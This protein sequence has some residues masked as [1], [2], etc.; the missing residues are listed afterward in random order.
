MFLRKKIGKSTTDCW[1]EIEKLEKQI[2]QA[3]AIIIGAGAGLSTSAGFHYAGERFKE[4]FGDFA[5]RYHFIDMYSGGF[6]PYET[7]EEHWTYWSRYIYINRYMDAP[8][9]VYN[10]LYSRVKEKDY[11]VLTTNVDHCFQKAGFDKHRL[12]YTQGDYGLFQCSEPCYQNTYNNE[13]VI[14]KMVEAQGYRVDGNGRLVV[15]ESRQPERKIPSELVPHC[16][17]CGKPMSMNLRADGTFIQDEGWYAASNRY[18]EFLKRHEN[19]FILFLELGVG[20]NTPAIIKYPFW[21]MT[22]ENPK[23]VYACINWG[24]AYA[25]KE[26]SERSICIDQDI[27]EV[28]GKIIKDNV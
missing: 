12:F 27:G 18:Y 11:F 25:P 5:N 4:Y 10:N 7:L 23:A 16:P 1:K 6:Y 22:A 26:I 9:P 24:Q 17:K 3:D 20:E 28:L 15:P 19:L 8:N 21:R 2:Q 14:R 13:A